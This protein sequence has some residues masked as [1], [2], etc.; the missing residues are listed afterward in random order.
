MAVDRIAPLKT[1]FTREAAGET[2]QLP[3]LMRGEPV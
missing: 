1:F 3:K 2:G